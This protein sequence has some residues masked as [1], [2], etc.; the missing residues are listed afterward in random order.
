MFQT[1]S[2]YSILVFIRIS[3]GVECLPLFSSFKIVCKKAP[4]F[5][6]TSLVIRVHCHQVAVAALGSSSS[7]KTHDLS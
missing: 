4:F 6:C 3:L 7:W 2:N 1:A 5:L